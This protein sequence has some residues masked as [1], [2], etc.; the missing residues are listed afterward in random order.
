M[1]ATDVASVH[2]LD[3]V[4]FFGILLLTVVTGIYFS[5][6]E[7]SSEEYL[8]GRRRMGLLPVSMSL[9]VSFVSAI[10]M[11]GIPAEVFV[12]GVDMIVTVLSVWGMWLAAATFVPLYYPLQL[13]S[14]YQYLDQRYHY[15]PLIVLTYALG[16]CTATIFM[17]IILFGPATALESVTGIPTWTNI[18]ALTLVCT[19]YTALGGMKAVLW[20]D[21]FQ[22]A[23]MLLGLILIIIVGQVRV[24]G[25]ANTWTELEKRGRM[26]ISL[27]PDPTIRLTIWTPILAGLTA[28]GTY[29]NQPA[30]MR[31]ESLPSQQK[32]Q[33]CVLIGS[34][35]H[36]VISLLAI[37]AGITVFAHYSQLGCEPMAM[38]VIS[39]PNQL[40]PYYLMD[41]VNIPGIPGIFIASIVAASLSSISSMQNALAAVSYQEILKPCIGQVSEFKETFIL[42]L[43]T[44]FYGLLSMMIAYGAQYIGGTLVQLSLLTLSIT[45]SPTG[46]VFFLGAIFTF[47]S[48][49]SAFLACLGT[50]SL[51]VAFHVTRIVTGIPETEYNLINET[52]W[53][54]T[55]HSDNW[56]DNFTSPQPINPYKVYNQSDTMLWNST[57]LSVNTV[58]WSILNLSQFLYSSCGVIATVLLGISFSALPWLRNKFN[59]EGKHLFPFVR[60]LLGK[61]KTNS[62]EI[63]DLQE[64]ITLLTKS[65]SFSEPTEMEV[66]TSI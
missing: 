25:I 35:G 11:Q 14:V 2:W 47:V 40:I 66:L 26:Q 42:K 51:F 4:V 65:R 8:Y 19:M 58:G 53:M 27:V 62:S 36:I 52:C 46:G 21:T 41:A 49:Q 55:N 18:L 33:L 29:G 63:K 5:C 1:V 45:D 54:G 24:G 30:M 7:N 10:T 34:A 59:V 38:E 44:V 43:I 20:N 23:I 31:Y 12:N 39:T 6:G 64:E 28:W 60:K 22:A 32:A 61:E 3:Y 9:F 16:I 15:R 57:E 17:G 50:I 56:R 13:S 48:G 37:L